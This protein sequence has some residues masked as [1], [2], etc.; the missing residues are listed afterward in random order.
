[1]MA[2]SP[3]QA[4]TVPN[5]PAGATTKGSSSLVDDY[6]YKGE[7]TTMIGYYSLNK[8]GSSTYSTSQTSITSWG[9]SSKVV[10]PSGGSFYSAG[11]SVSISNY[12]RTLYVWKPMYGKLY[13]AGTCNLRASTYTWSDSVTM[14]PA[15]PVS[16]SYSSDPKNS[17]HTWNAD[18]RISFKITRNPN[19]GLF[20][21]TYYPYRTL[22]G[23]VTF[24]VNNSSKIGMAVP[25]NGNASTNIDSKLANFNVFDEGCSGFDLWKFLFNGWQV[26]S[27]KSS[28]YD[29][30]N[31]DSGAITLSNQHL[32][33]A[34]TVNSVK[35]TPGSYSNYFQ[36]TSGSDTGF[37]L[38]SPRQ[39]TNSQ[40]WNTAAS[41]I[42][43]PA[44]IAGVSKAG[45]KLVSGVRQTA[46]LACN[47][48]S[49]FCVDNNAYAWYK[50]PLNNYGTKQM[51][52][53]CEP[54][55]NGQV[56]VDYYDY[57]QADYTPSQYWI[58]KANKQYTYNLS[59]PNSKWPDTFNGVL[60]GY[61][62]TLNIANT[63]ATAGT[64]RWDI[65]R[66]FGEYSVALGT[67][68]NT[69][70]TSSQSWG[71]RMA[72]ID[73]GY[74]YPNPW[75]NADIKIALP[76][77][78]YNN[79]SKTYAYS[80]IMPVTL[81][82]LKVSKPTNPDARNLKASPVTIKI[83]GTNKSTINTYC[84]SSGIPS[85]CNNLRLGTFKPGDYNVQACWAGNRVFK[86]TCSNVVSFKVY[87]VFSCNFSQ[88]NKPITIDYINPETGLKTVTGS[89]DTN[90]I[91]SG[92]LWKVTYPNINL[93]SDVKGLIGGGTGGYNVA[94]RSYIAGTP[95]GASEVRLFKVFGGNTDAPF[96][97][98]RQIG[99]FANIFGTG[100]SS[101]PGLFGGW[102]YA[103]PTDT[104]KAG[105]S[106][107][108]TWQMLPKTNPA[109]S[110]YISVAWPSTIGPN[111]VRIPMQLV[112]E[113]A[114]Y[115][116]AFDPWQLAG[117]PPNLGWHSCSSSQNGVAWN[118]IA[119]LPGGNPQT[120]KLTI[121]SGHLT[122]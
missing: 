22:G 50:I 15:Q 42:G 40:L 94:G 7:T 12:A 29:A 102:Y 39:P 89:A 80:D 104:G 28:W 23:A 11:G 43:A 13:P 27:C 106:K 97:L 93:S 38:E 58:M 52:V 107:T 34:N 96:E 61:S 71:N 108:K 112:R 64:D 2:V 37:K 63:W 26:D 20:G 35:Y 95:I 78:Q 119:P 86:A 83:T 41:N 36:E 60:T 17:S 25:A 54:E 116:E 31:I 73:C 16:M 101:L 91:R 10:T 5:C 53:N 118:P 46:S 122:N 109:Q 75:V 74:P 8:V 24:I 110:E 62:N 33:G 30:W 103:A 111:G 45:T 88:A 72:N 77:K 105:V 32:V 90:L 19:T 113:V 55:G 21:N 115:G 117:E 49:L 67:L 85:Y 68:F 79:T 121:V 66:N 81:A 114:V 47:T 70:N 57:G 92:Q 6:L 100:D 82:T 59:W 76:S 120:S 14:V 69:P 99:N 1:M 18:V 56:S 9:S 4:V 84:H 48:T 44:S 3:A 87:A 65:G 51:G 98:T